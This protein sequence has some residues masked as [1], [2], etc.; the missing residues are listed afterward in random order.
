MECEQKSRGLYL[1]KSSWTMSTRVCSAD[2]LRSSVN[3]Q[4]SSHQK[5][6]DKDRNKQSKLGCLAQ[7]LQR[8]HLTGLGTVLVSPVDM[9]APGAREVC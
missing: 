1:E 5:Y 2:F 4:S 3:T 7:V 9:V 8:K 6:T